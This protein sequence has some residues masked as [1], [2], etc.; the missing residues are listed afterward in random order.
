[1][2]RKL[3]IVENE[4]KHLK[5]IDKCASSFGPQLEPSIP[6]ARLDLIIYCVDF[7]NFKCHPT[8]MRIRNICIG[9]NAALVEAFP[10]HECGL[11][12]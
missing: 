11:A 9:T 2:I 8:I 7:V 12:S 6:S 4:T 1:M 5:T 10:C 3:E